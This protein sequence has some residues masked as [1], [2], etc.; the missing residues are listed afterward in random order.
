MGEGESFYYA[1]TGQT[2]AFCGLQLSV[3]SRLSLH[4]RPGNTFILGCRVRPGPAYYI[5]IRYISTFPPQSLYRPRVY[6]SIPTIGHVSPGWR[7]DLPLLGDSFGSDT[8]IVS[9]TGAPSLPPL[10]RLNQLG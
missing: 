6:L 8:I 9:G 1:D 4:A 2:L 5:L 3:R 10:T 7:H